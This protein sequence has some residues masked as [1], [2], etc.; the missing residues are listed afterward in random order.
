MPPDSN[1][2]IKG[3]WY[4]PSY[5]DAGDPP[6]S[7]RHAAPSVQS[8]P[9]RESE[10]AD[11]PPMA[12]AGSSRAKWA[13]YA[14]ANGVEIADDATRDEIIEAVRAAGVPVE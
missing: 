9:A 13:A 10:S 12:G 8:A 7:G 5:P 4:G 3:R 11:P 6:A 2:W 14:E 1:V